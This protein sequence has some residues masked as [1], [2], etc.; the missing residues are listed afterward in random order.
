[1][2]TV[3]AGDKLGPSNHANGELGAIESSLAALSRSTRLSS[4]CARPPEAGLE[5]YKVAR[6]A[7]VWPR[8]EWVLA[9]AAAPAA[10]CRP[11][12]KR[13]DGAGKTGTRRPGERA[14]CTCKRQSTP[15]WFQLFA[16]PPAQPLQS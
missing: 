14:K 2:N 12:P 16:R 7:L 13:I 3:G 9:A 8:A 1:M 6:S 5:N 15:L 11:A 10:P 4:V